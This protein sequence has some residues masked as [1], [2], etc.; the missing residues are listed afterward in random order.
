[1]KMLILIIAIMFCMA[2]PTS[3]N[4]AIDVVVLFKSYPREVGTMDG[5]LANPAGVKIANP[6]GQNISLN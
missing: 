5:V 1:M 4:I 6:A 3:A 2:I